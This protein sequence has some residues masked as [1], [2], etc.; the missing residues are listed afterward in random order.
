MKV[1]RVIRV[2]QIIHW[3]ML[4]YVALIIYEAWLIRIV[5]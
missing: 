2:S 3:C 5:L 1:F 4:A